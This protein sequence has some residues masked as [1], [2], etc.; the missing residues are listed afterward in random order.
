M[1]CSMADGMCTVYGLLYARDFCAHIIVDAL[2]I[3]AVVLWLRM[4]SQ[5]SSFP[6][7]VN[8][9]KIIMDDFMSTWRMVQG[10]SFPNLL[11][12]MSC[13]ESSVNIYLNLSFIIH[14]VKIC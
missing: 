8:N 4:C 11:V 10:S 6:S 1:V 12:H 2:S 7:T 5:L 13:V 3:V 14:Q 9:S